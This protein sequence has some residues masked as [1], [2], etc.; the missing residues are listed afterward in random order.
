MAVIQ[1]K[2]INQGGIADSKY[3]GLANSVH[4]M[5]GIDLHSIPGLIQVN[6]KMTRHDSG[7]ITDLCKA[8]IDCSNGIRYWFSST[9]GKIW[10][11]KNDVYTLVYTTSP[12]SGSA[13]CLG[14]LEHNNYIYWATSDKLHRIAKNNADGS[15]AW[16]SNAVPN[17]ATFTN[18]DVSFHPMREVNLVLY[19]GDGNLIAQVDANVFSADALDIPLPHR[20]SALGKMGTDLLIGTFIASNVNLSKVFRWNTY[21]VSFTNDDS[22]NENGISCFLEADN[23]V[24]VYAGNSGSIY[25]YNGEYLEFY[26]RLPG[27]YSPNKRATIHPYA[28]AMFKGSLPIFGVSNIE[29]NP[30]DLGIWSLGKYGRGYNTVLNLEFPISVTDVDGYNVLTGLEIGA[31]IVSGVNIYVSW[32]K[33]TSYGIDKLDYSNKIVKPF[34]ETRI[35]APTRTSATPFTTFK[36]SYESLPSGTSLIIKTKADHA[37]S[38]SDSDEIT[39]TIHKWVFANASRLQAKSIQLRIEALCS[40][41][42]SPTIEEIDIEL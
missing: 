34:I 13:S 39:D 16:A 6:Q 26:K 5:V 12:S 41:N 7:E 25:S 20:A 22:V 23:Y 37:A 28:S 15:S 11:E 40:S 3:S 29:G 14:A 2:D 38:F 33:D 30:C 36:V 32:K 42:N 31:I 1:I 8:S 17:W 19:I 4:R 27:T 10:Q 35:I 18:K 21:S 24:F 9:S